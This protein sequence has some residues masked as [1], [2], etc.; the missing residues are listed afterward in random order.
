[1]YAAAKLFQRGGKYAGIAKERL[2]RVESIRN[3]AELVRAALEYNTKARNSDTYLYYIIC[4]GLLKAK[5]VDINK[6]SLKDGL[7]RRKEYN[8]PN[9]ETVRRTRQKIQQNNPE[10]AGTE[11]TEVMR[12]IR[13]EQFK[14]YARS[15]K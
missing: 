15:V 11:E 5:G 4:K 13:E 1:M 9:F 2:K 12:T 14:N 10:L 6:I 7:L 8:L 3:T